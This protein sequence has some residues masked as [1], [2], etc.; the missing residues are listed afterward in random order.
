LLASLWASLA[1]AA[2]IAFARLSSQR[3]LLRRIRAEWGCP[4]QKPRRI[5]RVAQYH[6]SRLKF[7]TSV[8][9]SV[10]DGT[11]RD[12]DLDAV[13]ALLD[14]T[15]STLG[16]QAL[17]DRLRSERS[18][19][20]VE[21]FDRLATALSETDAREPVQAA[22]ARLQDPQGYDL[23]WMT[24]TDAIAT[25]PWIAAFPFLT[26][27][28]VA[29]LVVG[30]G[31]L[32]IAPV[33]LAT[34]V[35]C[36][37]IHYFTDP[38]LAHLSA[39][40][41][42]IAPLVS[43]MEGV[44]RVN[45]TRLE[46]H[47]RKLR[48]SASDLQSL[49]RFSRWMSDDPLM[50]PPDAIPLSRLT[51]DLLRAIIGYLNLLFFVDGTVLFLGLPRLRSNASRLLSAVAALGEIDAAIAVAS[52]RAGLDVW[53]RPTF[54]PCT[55]HLRLTDVRHPLVESAV[56]NSMELCPPHGVLITGS[57]MSGK[58]TWLRAIGVNAVLAQSIDTCVAS[59]YEAP[60]LTIRSCIVRTDD[61]LTGKSYYA[62]EVERIT[63][64]LTMSHG[65]A[66][67]LFLLD[68]LFRGTNAV[69][70]VAAA[71]AVLRDIVQS[72]HHLVIVATHDGE[73]TDLLDGVYES[74]HF[75]E[76]AN[77]EGLAFDYALQRGPA[78][79]RNAIALL[80]LHG[81][82]DTVVQHALRRAEELDRK[83]ATATA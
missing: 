7:L 43:A 42:Q 34:I 74:F 45:D 77:A 4:V 18:A 38:T 22:L 76:R 78:T 82:S 31:S 51:N 44:S 52:F 15:E 50:L 23:W 72:R 24:E 39:G 63:A 26:I 57:N 32:H 79:S 28:T 30:F 67:H 9:S 64:L 5:D 65:S 49:K 8:E 56:P 17:Y 19:H 2:L 29:T 21:E 66:P 55:A 36:T 1:L 40:F 11:W 37:F 71:E 33:L 60:H 61:I 46:P 80:R 81:A 69:E 14:R 68:E 47:L 75:G 53:T 27:A 13:F 20:R 12:L 25:P 83:R 10:D 73:L 58:S 6:F 3:R 16:Q 35:F 41:R 48:G 59:R 62:M 54:L 70:R